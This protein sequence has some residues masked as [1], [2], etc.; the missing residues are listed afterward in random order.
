M[1]GK[2]NSV[3]R[4]IFRAIAVGTSAGAL[5]LYFLKEAGM[6]TIILLMGIGL[7]ALSVSSLD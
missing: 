6:N 5:V 4:N 2:G 1:A 3:I 7:F